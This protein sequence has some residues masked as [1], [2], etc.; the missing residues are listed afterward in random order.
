VP[1]PS[2]KKCEMALRSAFHIG[3]PARSESL[4]N[5]AFFVGST[6]GHNES[7]PQIPFPAGDAHPCD[8]EPPERSPELV[9]R[10][11]R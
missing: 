7:N 11:R 4:R 2:S 6:L 3:A 9:R 10:E 8:A 1:P 5:L